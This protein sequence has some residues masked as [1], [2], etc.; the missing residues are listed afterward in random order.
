[1]GFY[2][3]DGSDIISLRDYGPAV[4]EYTDSYDNL[5]VAGLWTNSVICADILRAKALTAKFHG[6]PILNNSLIA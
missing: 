6:V 5:I 4:I 1:M 2:W 3:S